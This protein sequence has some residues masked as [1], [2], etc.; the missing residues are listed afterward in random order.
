MTLEETNNKIREEL[1]RFTEELVQKNVD[2]NNSLHRPNVF[3][4]DPMEGLKAR[5]SDKLNRILSKGM[6]DKTEDSFRDLFGYYIHHCIM[7]EANES[8]NEANES[9]NEYVVTGNESRHGFAIGS[10]IVEEELEPGC[11]Q[12]F[13]LKGSPELRAAVFPCDRKIIK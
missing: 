10:T 9:K 6:D 11:F 2:Y 7:S 3:G 4:Q 13:S 1:G 5:M 8:K 12:M